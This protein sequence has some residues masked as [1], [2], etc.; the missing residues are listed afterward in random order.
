MNSSSL[1]TECDMTSPNTSSAA[2]GVIDVSWFGADFHLTSPTWRLMH[3]EEA[4]ASGDFS[5]EELDIENPLAAGWPMHATALYAS[6]WW[7]T[8]ALWR[9]GVASSVLGAVHLRRARQIGLAVLA[10]TPVGPPSQP[11]AAAWLAAELFDLPSRNTIRLQLT[12]P[13]AFDS[14]AAGRLKS[15]ITAGQANRLVAYALSAMGV[16]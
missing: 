7:L 14:E 5:C 3:V 11:A 8:E 4:A 16:S 1:S 12:R 6:T 13:E 15:E 10:I 2:N 9:N